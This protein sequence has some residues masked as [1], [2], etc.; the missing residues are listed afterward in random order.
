[1]QLKLH[2]GGTSARV[3]SMRFM[4]WL[5]PAA[6]LAAGALPLCAEDPKGPSQD[7]LYN[8]LLQPNQDKTS[9]FNGKMFETKEFNLKQSSFDKSEP[10]KMNSAF[11]KSSSME[12][13]KNGAYDDRSYPTK[14]EGGGFNSD[15]QS[16]IASKS[17]ATK[18]SDFIGKSY[19]PGGHDVETK[20]ATGFEKT[21]KDASKRYLGPESP[22]DLSELGIIQKNL[23]KADAER[24]EKT[25]LS[26]AEIKQLLENP[27]LVRTKRSTEEKFGIDP[28]S[29]PAPAAK[30]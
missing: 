22:E 25:R 16:D 10:L 23:S 21:A 3:V 5:L 14:V 1:M 13:K 9:S 17:Y 2:N 24:A 18:D 15:K 28:A 7:D 29:L 26:P 4:A 27:V 20:D 30:P 19:N 8:K 6:L 11:D 12:M